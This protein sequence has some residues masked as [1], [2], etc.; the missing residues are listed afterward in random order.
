MSPSLLIR[1]GTVILPQGTPEILDVAVRGDRIAAVAPD[2]AASPAEVIDATG[3]WVTPGLIDTHLH[4]GLEADVMDASPEA[5]GTIACHLARHGVTAWLPTT[6]ACAADELERILAAIESVRA[7][8]EAGARIL[9][10]HLESNF[11]APRFKGAQPAPFLRLP[12]D[13]EIEAV[14]RRH[15]GV[16]RLVTLAPELPGALDLI[17]RL[18]ASG[19]RVAVGHTDA[20]YDQVLAAV[21]AGATRVTHLCNAQRGFHHREPGV[22]GAG[23]D[24]DSLACEIIAD[25]MHV[26]PAGLRI[27]R[28]CKGSEGLILVSDALRGTGL[29]PGRRELGGQVTILDG[30]V[31]RLEDGTIAGSCITL[32]AAVRTMIEQGGATPAEA[33]AMATRAPADSLGLSGKGRLA[34]GGDA[35]VTIFDPEWQVRATVIGGVVR[36]RREAS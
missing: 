12:G 5:L 1:G 17:R 30:R 16:I 10:A 29:P 11:L 21:E 24:L 14:I 7:R 8:A 23:L 6:V 26:H 15:A 9:G 20:T 22:L 31:A 34:V 18:V 32:D 19:I 36:Y 13:A 27:A 28:R 4:G 3:C 25:G 2:L 35:D 33:V